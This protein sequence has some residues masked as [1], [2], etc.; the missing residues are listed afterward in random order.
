M[1]RR[2][3]GQ[4]LIE[5]ALILILAAVIVIVVLSVM[6]AHSSGV[7]NSTVGASASP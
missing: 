4:N 7:Y 3:A 6:G 2:Q 1:T 5:F